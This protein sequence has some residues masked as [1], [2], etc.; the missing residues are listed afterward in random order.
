MA[1]GLDH[2]V[3][4]VR[5]LNAAADAY[6]RLGF[7]VGARN[8]HPWGTHNHLVQFQGFFIEILTV[9]EPEKLGDDGFS[10]MFG[11]FN[12]RFLEHREGFSLLILES[13]DAKADQRAFEAA[14][15]AASEA[16]RFERDSRQGST[17]SR[18]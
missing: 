8:R 15:I 5:D 10:K 17:R 11:N 14:G 16:M 6:R 18:T 3:H 7:T 2:I 9:A 4:A 13:R 12:R 1:R